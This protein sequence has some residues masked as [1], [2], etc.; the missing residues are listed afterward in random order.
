MEK[1]FR[2]SG[3]IMIGFLLVMT[4]IMIV[5]LLAVNYL[6][7]IAIN[8]GIDLGNKLKETK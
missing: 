3:A 8:K 5:V 1:T 4:T 2:D 7:S 6:P